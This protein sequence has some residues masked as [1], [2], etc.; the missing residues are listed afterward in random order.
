MSEKVEISKPLYYATAGLTLA[1]IGGLG[2]LAIKL[3]C[4]D[5]ESASETAETVAEAIFGD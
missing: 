2:F 5:D 3:L 1:A 4:A